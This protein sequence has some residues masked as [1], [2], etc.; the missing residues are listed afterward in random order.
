MFISWSPKRT[1]DAFRVI[2]EK[3]RIADS[4]HSCILSNDSAEEDV[5]S[6]LQVSLR[7]LGMAECS[8]FDQ[9][10]DCGLVLFLTP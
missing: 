4:T 1:T 10:N 6:I 9:C 3:H 8:I 2:G 5:Q 7:C